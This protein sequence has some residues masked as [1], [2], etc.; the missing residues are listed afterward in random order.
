MTPRNPYQDE[1]GRLFLPGLNK[2]ILTVM[3]HDDRCGHNRNQEEHAQSIRQNRT[4][5]DRK[6]IDQGVNGNDQGDRKCDG[7]SFEFGFAFVRFRTDWLLQ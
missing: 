6:T 2:V 1:A 3:S 7:Y 4:V 5:L